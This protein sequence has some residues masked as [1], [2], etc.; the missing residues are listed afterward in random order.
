MSA[1]WERALML[2][3]SNDNTDLTC[4]GKRK[5]SYA[6]QEG[7]LGREKG[8]WKG[9]VVGGSLVHPGRLKQGPRCWRAEETEREGQ[10]LKEAGETGE[11]RLKG[12]GGGSP[13]GSHSSHPLT[14]L[15]SQ[16]MLPLCH[17]CAGYQRFRGCNRSDWDLLTAPSSCPYQP[18]TLLWTLALDTQ[19]AP[20][21]ALVWQWRMG[22]SV[23][24][25]WPGQVL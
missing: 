13:P 8:T 24:T 15:L 25:V 14:S 4:L 6:D 22:P 16:G 12:S 10:W 23:L 18:L 7:D 9:P 21:G 1:T 19:L 5:K 20:V 17:T 3:K 11:T 2:W